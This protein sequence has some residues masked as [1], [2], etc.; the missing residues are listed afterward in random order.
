MYDIM[1]QAEEKLVQ[2]GT[3]LTVS[4]MFFIFSVVILATIMFITLSIYY[5]KKPPEK[6]K[7][8]IAIFLISIFVG[9]AITTLIFVYRIVGLGIYKLLDNS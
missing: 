4:V 6:R 5:S 1:R 2:V 8:Q 3:D 7:S 9:W